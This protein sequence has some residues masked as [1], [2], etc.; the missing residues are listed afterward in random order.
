MKIYDKYTLKK[1]LPDFPAGTVLHWD[2]WTE[3]YTELSYIGLSDEPKLKYRVEYVQE[4]PEWFEPV[5]T[6]KELYQAFPKDFA[7]EHFYF[8]ELR[9]NKM[10]RFCHDAQE[11]LA[12]DEF[13]ERAT[14]IFKELYEEKLTKLTANNQ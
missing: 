10:C 1:D 8:G 4:H 7:K 9:H 2:L 3:K 12:S 13:Q 6:A 11:I 14:A 5:G